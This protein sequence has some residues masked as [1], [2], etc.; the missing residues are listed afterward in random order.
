V[1][2][3][4]YTTHFKER[5]GALSGDAPSYLLEISHPQL[6]VP[7]RICN[8][9]QDIVS[10]GNTFTAM[11]FRVSLPDDIAQRCRARSSPS[12]TSAA[13]SRSGSTPRTA[14]AAR[15]FG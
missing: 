9:T 14:A 2:K 13:S 3:T 4:S 15:R 11:G 10:N 8:D 1:A 12:T 7:I 6:A 5:V